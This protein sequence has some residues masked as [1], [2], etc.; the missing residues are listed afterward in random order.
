LVEAVTARTA[1]EAARPAESAVAI[2]VAGLPVKVDGARNDDIAAGEY[3][4]GLIGGVAR[5]SDG[6]GAWDIN[7]SEV[8]DPAVR[9]GYRLRGSRVERSV[10]PG[11][12]AT[13]AVLRLNV[14]GREEQGNEN[15]SRGYPTLY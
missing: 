10:S 6:D 1:V 14:S 11:R 3:R 15:G 8:E 2:R 13:E 12:T 4:Q 7:C 5:V 9:H